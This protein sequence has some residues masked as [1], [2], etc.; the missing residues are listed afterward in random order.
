M[1]PSSKYNINDMINDARP[2]HGVST[3]L[4]CVNEFQIT[5][6]YAAAEHIAAEHMC[7]FLGIPCPIYESETTANFWLD[8]AISQIEQLNIP[9]VT[10]LPWSAFSCN[11]DNLARLIRF[12]FRSVTHILGGS[13]LCIVHLDPSWKEDPTLFFFNPSKTGQGEES[14]IKNQ[15]KQF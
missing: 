2:V 14:K 15:L 10:I 12:G 3:R 5:D 4:E 7:N 13:G 1:G 11:A 8:W 6:I 9:S